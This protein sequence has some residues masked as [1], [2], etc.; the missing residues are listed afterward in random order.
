MAKIIRLTEQDLTRIVRK[1]LKEQDSWAS[2][3]WKKTEQNLSGMDAIKNFYNNMSPVERKKKMDK[4]KLALNKCIG[5]EKTK[6][7][8][9]EGVESAFTCLMAIFGIVHS[10]GI[11]TGVFAPLCA[12]FLTTTGG[13]VVDTIECIKEEYNKL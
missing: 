7:L 5:P 9:E 3:E 13:S 10:F 2:R 8:V 4:L 6:K 12:G 11:L 1:V